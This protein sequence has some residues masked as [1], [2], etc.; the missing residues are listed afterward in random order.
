MDPLNNILRTGQ[1]SGVGGVGSLTENERTAGAEDS[2]PPG[3]SPAELLDT[4][5]LPE[6][7]LSMRGVSVDTLLQAVADEQRRNGVQSA[8]NNL[9]VQGEQMSAEGEKRLE[10]IKKQLDELKNQSWWDKFCKAF[11][12]IGAIFGAIAS[13]ATIAVGACTGNVGL[14]VAGTIGLLATT[15]S[16]VSLASDGKYSLA[17]G[18]TE[19]GKAMGMSDEAAQWFGFGM[20]LA[21]MLTTIAVSFGAS[22]AASSGKVVQSVSEMTGNAA[23]AMSAMSKVSSVGNIAQGVTGIGSAVTSAGLAVSNYN[24]A[25]I[26]ANKV[27]IDAVLEQLRNNIKMSQELI[28]EELKASDQLMTDVKEILEDC[29]QTATAILTANPSAA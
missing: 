6:L 24:L 2:L 15:D 8:V 28:E 23:K 21:V 5:D 25:H 17:A 27:D 14:I 18:F 29:S 22:S 4:L 7:P 13:V 10:E 9:E 20:N 19:L 1:S 3:M 16:I 12:I 11:Q 26:E